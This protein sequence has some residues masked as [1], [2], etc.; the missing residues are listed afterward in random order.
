MKTEK[1][2]AYL[3]KTDQPSRYQIQSFTDSENSKL[4]LIKFFFASHVVKGI[5]D[6]SFLHLASGGWQKISFVWTLIRFDVKR[7]LQSK[8][9]ASSF[10][11][12]RK[13]VETFL[14]FVGTFDQ[15]LSFTLWIL[16]G[17][18]FFADMKL[19]YFIQNSDPI[20]Y[21]EKLLT[22]KKKVE[23]GGWPGSATDT[24]GGVAAGIW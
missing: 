14:M 15:I 13:K 3:H 18:V 1:C 22:W 5:Q 12:Y 10:V 17:I 20:N 11:I 16:S 23:N 7:F 21:Y 8:I 24:G 2:F 6:L 4:A 19:N 9:F